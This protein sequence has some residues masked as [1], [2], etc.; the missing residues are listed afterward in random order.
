MLDAVK[1]TVIHLTLYILC[2]RHSRPGFNGPFRAPFGH[3]SKSLG[4]FVASATFSKIASLTE[5]SSTALTQ[6]RAKLKLLPA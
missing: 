4:N 3:Q 1:L 2:K 6:K 5:G